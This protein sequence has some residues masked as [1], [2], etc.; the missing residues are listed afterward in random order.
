M[1]YRGSHQKTS[2]CMMQT[3]R[4]IR[5]CPCGCPKAHGQAG[6][7]GQKAQK[8]EGIQKPEMYWGRHTA[9]AYHMDNGRET[10]FFGRM[11]FG[12]KRVTECLRLSWSHFVDLADKKYFRY[13]S[14]KKV[15]DKS[16]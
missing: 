15:A 12:R 6:R 11:F 2:A 16:E 5:V 7:A 14:K 4:K 1:P 13:L 3:G 9:V 8:K 10:V